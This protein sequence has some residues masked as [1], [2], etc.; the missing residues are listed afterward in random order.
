MLVDSVKSPAGWN[1]VCARGSREDGRRPL[2]LEVVPLLGW[3]E[4]KEKFVDAIQLEM[5][6]L[7]PVGNR[8]LSCDQIFWFLGYAHDK[9][10]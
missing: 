6:G 5:T 4:R 3:G 7:L 9:N 1:A 10:L 2:R 8:V